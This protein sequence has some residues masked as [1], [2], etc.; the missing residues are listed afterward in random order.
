MFKPCLATDLLYPP[1]SRMMLANPIARGR[2]RDVG[3]CGTQ[4]LNQ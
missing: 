4:K 3:F 2:K 1:S